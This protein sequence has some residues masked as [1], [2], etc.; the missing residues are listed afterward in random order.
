M[1]PNPLAALPRTDHLLDAATSLVARH[2]RDDTRA[3]LTTALD[4]TRAQVAAGAA[5]PAPGEPTTLIATN[6]AQVRVECTRLD[7]AL[8]SWVDP[9]LVVGLYVVQQKPLASRRA[10]LSLA[11]EASELD[12]DGAGPGAAASGCSA[13]PARALSRPTRAP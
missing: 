7:P 5:L 2:G 11:S 4:E 8:F 13:R 10:S 6:V 9:A 12:E 1:D 3:A